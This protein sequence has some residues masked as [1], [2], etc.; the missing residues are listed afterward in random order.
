MTN[1]QKLYFFLGALHIS[2]VTLKRDVCC[3]EDLTIEEIMKI[4][5]LDVKEIL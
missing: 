3:F 2:A 4:I 5:I 1:E